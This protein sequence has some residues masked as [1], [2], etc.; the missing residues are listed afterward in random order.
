MQTL[1]EVRRVLKPGGRLHVVD[2]GAP[3]TPLG[4]QLARWLHHTEHMR[5]NVEGRL[6]ELLR[7]AGFADAVEAAR[8]PTIVGSLSFYRGVKPAVASDASAA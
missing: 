1:A 6:P 7:E 5:D 3:A 4:A 8:H 2:F